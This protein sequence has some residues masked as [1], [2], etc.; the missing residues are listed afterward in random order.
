MHF[1]QWSSGIFGQVEYSI[2]GQISN[3]NYIEIGGNNMGKFIDSQIL[4]NAFKLKLKS[5]ENTSTS[6]PIHILI[7]VMKQFSSG[8]LVCTPHCRKIYQFRLVRKYFYY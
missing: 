2:I 5:N 3:I 1:G 6:F 4:A 7:M 8:T